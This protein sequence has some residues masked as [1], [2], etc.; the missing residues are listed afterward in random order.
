MFSTI[1]EM[2][3]SC[4]RWTIRVN[5]LLSYYMSYK[6]RSCPYVL[7]ICVVYLYNFKYEKNYLDSEYFLPVACKKKRLNKHD[8]TIKN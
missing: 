2:C 8:G 3:Y 1:A 4:M 5:N 6:I 7:F